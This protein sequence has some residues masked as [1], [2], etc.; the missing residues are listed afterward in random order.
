MEF[1]EQELEVVQDAIELLFHNIIQGNPTDSTIDHK[2]KTTEYYP[3]RVQ[4][5]AVKLRRA[6]RRE[7]KLGVV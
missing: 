6:K 2:M 1:T 3:S 7:L 4:E 5:I